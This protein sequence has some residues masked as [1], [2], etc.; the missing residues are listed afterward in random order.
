MEGSLV[1]FGFLGVSK[2]FVHILHLATLAFITRRL[3]PELYGQVS[4]FLMVTQFLYLLT[5]SWTGVGYMRYSVLYSTQGK[6]VSEVFWGR[7]FLLFAFIFLV[8]SA[9]VLGKNHLLRYLQL[10]SPIIVIVFLHF[11]SLI[12]ADY[13]RLFAQVATEFKRLGVLQLMEKGALFL[14]IWLWGES[15]FTILVLYIVT[16]LGF[17][18]YFF[19]TVSHSLYWP[20][21]LNLSLCKKLLHFSYPLILTSAGGFIFG[22]ADIVIIKHFL[23]L[24]EVGIY[25]LA[26]TGLGAIEAV[27]LLMPM[28]LTPIFVSLATQGEDHLTDR[29]IL[30]VLPQISILWGF[31]I[32][33]LALTSLWVIPIVF[34]QDF[35]ESASIFLVLLITL[36][37]SVITGLCVPILVGY[38]MVTKMVLVNFSASIINLFLDI[39]F[40]PRIGIMGAALATTL[41]YG[42]ITISYYELVKR[43]FDFAPGRLVLFIGI[44]ALQI[45]GLLL[46][47][48][49]LIRL[50]ITVIAAGMYLS[51]S[52][53]LDI[54]GCQ[55]KGIY[56]SLEMPPLLKKAFIHICDY[57]GQSRGCTR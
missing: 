5:G 40:I 50:T 2:I 1:N 24:K 33:F 15:L 36:N 23:P 22:W 47:D 45:G 31:L 41:S 10:P 44:V 43:R 53:L 7:S 52:K 57:Y 8:G 17:E 3:G 56:A 48:S 9:L 35:T 30:R 29:Y 4:V 28:V 39:V 32:M 19:S 14:L 26:Y 54:F 18:A 46:C 25:S 16:A 37:L 12:I 34:G 42:F 20:F 49:M 21:R 11:F 27:V 13:T 38:E 55:D 51:G 6:R